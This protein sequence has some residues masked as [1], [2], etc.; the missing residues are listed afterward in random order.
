MGLD[1]QRFLYPCPECLDVMV[2]I[3]VNCFE[4]ATIQMISSR[5]IGCGERLKEEQSKKF[6]GC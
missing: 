2:V 5:Q 1:V 4:R 6:I 3:Q